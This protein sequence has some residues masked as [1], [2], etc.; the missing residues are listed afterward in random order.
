MKVMVFS[1]LHFFRGRSYLLDTCQWVAGMVEQTRPD[2]VVFG[3]DLNHSHSY[4]EVDT[5][6]AMTQS[7]EAVARAA[8]KVTG[9]KLVAISGNH[10]TALKDG[11]KNILQAIGF[12]SDNM[13]VI[14]DPTRDGDFLFVPHPPA[15]KDAYFAFNKRAAEVGAGA[16]AMFSHVELADVRYTPASSHCTEHPFEV[17]SSVKLIVN[18]HYHHPEV[19]DGGGRRVVIAGS[20]CYH[21][22][23]DMMVS[24]P[25]GVV[26]V[27][28]PTGSADV[29]WHKNPHG[30]IYHTI[31]TSQIEAISRHQDVGRMMLR[32]KVES[33]QDYEAS[34]EGINLLRQHATSVRVVGANTKASSSIYKAE[35][36]TIGLTSPEDLVSAYVR[37]N[38]LSKAHHDYANKLLSEASK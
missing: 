5:L 20:P 38:S 7:F 9:K 2:L 35:T 13:Q 36:S 28:N 37:K 17:P 33:Q 21:S 29:V 4:V 30:P 19:R 15:N 23:A 32:V 24:T 8:V 18:G 14:T 25:R 16:V 34:K 31:E 12:V 6:H 10:D 26:V 1:D 27:T 11:G 3:G 22:Y